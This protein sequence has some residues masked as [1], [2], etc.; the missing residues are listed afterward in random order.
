MRSLEI[1]LNFEYLLPNYLIR[2]LQVG[3]PLLHIFLFPFKPIYSGGDLS[4]LGQRYFKVL[5]R[6]IQLLYLQADAFLDRD[7]F[8]LVDVSEALY[9]LLDLL[10]F[11][12]VLPLELPDE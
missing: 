3:Q 8:A 4:D 1:C 10:L 2:G 7:V 11:E 5:L 9:D 12:I 6:L